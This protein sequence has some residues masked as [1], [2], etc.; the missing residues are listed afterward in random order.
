MKSWLAPYVYGPCKL[1]GIPWST[2]STVKAALRWIAP[3]RFIWRKLISETA[4]VP[5][6]DGYVES[7]HFDVVHFPTQAAYLTELPTIYQPHDLQHLHYPHFFS[8]T[9]F[10]LREKMYRTFC[11]RASYVC[12]HTEWTK[13][14]V[15]N[16]YGIVED[17]VVVIPWGSVFEA[18]K[19]PSEEEIRA[20]VEKYGL[21]SRYFLY[22]AVTWPHKNHEIII[23]A[24]C[25]LKSE[26]GIAP[27]VIFTGSLTDYRLTLDKLAKDL[28]VF[29]EVHYLGFVTPAELQAIYRTATAMIYPSKFEG[30]GLPLLEAFH[31]CLPVLSS[32][33]STMPEVAKDGALYFD[34]DSPTELSALMRTI[35]DKP[36]LRQDLIRKGT[37]QLS[38]YSINN[39]AAKFQELYARTAALS[40]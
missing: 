3:L 32:N 8:K 4:Y 29:Q 35:L 20:T 10:A 6:S 1:E 5:Y 23:R 12:V 17:K 2:L 22:P 30:F 19:N 37:L 15:M 33:A 11:N 18:Y 28:G 26:N 25:I 16:H 40:S 21:P 36:E 38:H 31:A 27:H 13:R 34:P 24:I 14:D 9:V 7:N 39:T